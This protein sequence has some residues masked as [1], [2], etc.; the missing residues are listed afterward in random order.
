MRAFVPPGCVSCDDV[1]NEIYAKEFGN[2]KRV[3]CGH[4]ALPFY[5]GINVSASEFQVQRY[6]KAL[7]ILQ[8][9][10][11]TGHRVACYVC[12]NGIVALDAAIFALDGATKCLAKGEIHP[13]G[14]APDAGHTTLFIRSGLVALPASDSLP[15]KRKGGRTRKQERALVAYDE[16]Y[17]RGHENTRDTREIVARRVGAQAGVSVSFDTIDKALK[18]RQKEAELT[19]KTDVKPTQN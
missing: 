14:W 5:K 18:S 3:P 13:R 4:W 6:L 9:Q 7:H 11:Y 10:L 19:S 15:A 12:C 2:T 17:P 16:I 1:L 8:G